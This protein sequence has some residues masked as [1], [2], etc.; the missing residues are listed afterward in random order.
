M[1]FKKILTLI[2]IVVIGVST[3]AQSSY[4]AFLK[5]EPTSEAHF[6]TLL[7]DLL[8]RGDGS[9]WHPGAGQAYFEFFHHHFPGIKPQEIIDGTNFVLA[10]SLSENYQIGRLHK[11]TRKLDWW[12]RDWRKGERVGIYNG[13]AWTSMSC[14]NPLFAENILI[15][16]DDYTRKPD[17]RL[18][19][20]SPSKTS[21][22]DVNV[23]VVPVFIEKEKEKEVYI[24]FEVPVEVPVYY[25]GGDYYDPYMYPQQPYFGQQVYSPYPATPPYIGGTGLG[26]GLYDLLDL[27]ID[28]YQAYN[29]GQ[30][31]RAI[32]QGNDQNWGGGTV[33]NNNVYNNSV[34]NPERNY[35][36]RPPRNDNNWPDNPP[37]SNPGDDFQGPGSPV[38][39]PG[40]NGNYDNTWANS[41]SRTAS[42]Q[43]SVRSAYRNDNSRN[44]STQSQITNASRVQSRNIFS[45]E[46]ASSSV[47]PSKL[48]NARGISQRQQVIPQTRAQRAPQTRPS[49][50]M[51]VAPQRNGS[52]IGSSIRGSSNISSRGSSVRG[53]M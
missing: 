41:T 25:G 19:E 13:K 40:N 38:N 12:E 27:G 4:S 7:A 26:L 11:E 52:N 49:T 5:I 20:S 23:T 42:L 15:E 21:N 50:S 51:S 29:V 44:V 18:V 48:T 10:S 37:P 8:V 9:K 36:G 17:T 53:S 22:Q 43:S 24:P 39:I 30:I 16:P 47:N 46:M 3:K 32:Q 33:I 35:G 34:Y 31:A 2:A 14:G 1:F 6:K 28:F 45:R